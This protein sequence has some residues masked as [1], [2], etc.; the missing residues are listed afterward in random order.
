M[1]NHR[2]R[3]AIVIL[4]AALLA[5]VGGCCKDRVTQKPSTLPVYQQSLAEIDRTIAAAHREHADLGERVAALAKKN[6]GQPYEIY[7][8]GEAPF[9]TIDPQPVFTFEKSD[10]VVFVEH[11]Y[12]MALTDNLPAALTMLQRI[13][14]RNGE[15]GVLTRNHYTEA[16]W[17]VAN[18]WLFED[19]TQQIGG[20]SAS[21]YTQRVNW[22][23]FFKDRYQL[24][25]DI[26]PRTIEQAYIPAEKVLAVADKLR[27][28]DVIE[29]VR[30]TPPNLYVGHLGLIVKVDGKNVTVIHS[31]SPKVKSESLESI[32]ERSNGGFAFLRPHKDALARLRAHDGP[33]APK[34]STPPTS[35]ISW[36]DYVKSVI[37]R[38]MAAKK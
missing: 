37:N 13:R 17:N 10:C 38:D 6:L 32:V 28:G 21:V 15:I 27:P 20:E 26:E 8:L 29:F 9:E 4:A 30:G 1:P 35:S 22:A 5:V 16:D 18:R 12:A 14:Y 7:L 11:T 3:N 19:I 23:K 24:D 36:P 25:T 33:A 31:T 2:P 34:V